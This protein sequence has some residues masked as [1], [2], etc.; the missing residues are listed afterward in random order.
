MHTLIS[1]DGAL[2]AFSLQ[3]GQICSWRTPDGRELLYTSPDA[4][5]SGR[6][7]IRGGIPVIFPQFARE[8]PLLKHGFA[9][10]RRWSLLD[11]RLQPSGAGR[12]RLGLQHQA[13]GDFGHD[14]ELEIDALF[15]GQK[16]EVTLLARNSGRQPFRFTAALHTYLRSE[17][18]ATAVHGLKGCRYR[19][20]AR[21]GEIAMAGDQ[22][23]RLEGEIDRI[24]HAVPRPVEVRMGGAVLESSQSGFEDVVVWNPG[25]EL[26]AT[27]DDLPRD[28]WQHFVCVEAALI[29]TPAELDPGQQW[30]GTQTLRRQGS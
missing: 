9:R 23:L 22:P 13:D 4:D 11:S 6:T 17:A 7:A 18:A 26:G 21:G 14:C 1:A 20:S 5:F 24:Y 30:S 3:G 16:L 8:G 29:G 15:A 10:L 19:D 27:I 12:I 28:G 2:L 25:A